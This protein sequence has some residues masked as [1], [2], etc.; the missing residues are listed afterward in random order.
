MTIQLIILSSF[1][2]LMLGAAAWRWL[3]YKVE[4]YG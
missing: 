1:A 3:F 4:F 2:V